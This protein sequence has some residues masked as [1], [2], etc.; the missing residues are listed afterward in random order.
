M[1]GRDAE[2]AALLGMAESARAGEVTLAL[3]TGEAG[4]GKSRLIAELTDRV[5]DALV[6]TGHGVDMST[7]EIPYGVLADTLRDLHRQPDAPELTEDERAALA[8]LLPGRSDE[9]AAGNRAGLMSAALGLLERLAA[10]R[11][12]CWVVEDLHWADAATRDLVNLVARTGHG[13]L[14]VVA[15]VRTDDPETAPEQQARMTA[16]LA[17]LSRLP[18]TETVALPRLGPTDVQRQLAT[19]V[20]GSL[21][22]GLAQQIADLSD[23]L[24]FAI[25][26]LAAGQGRP[27]L[28]SVAAVAAA[29]LASLSTSARLVVEAVAIGDGHLRFR[30]L[31]EVLALSP[32]DVDAGLREAADAG[33]LAD[34]TEDDTLGFRHA[35]L[36]AAVD[37][38][39]PPGARRTWHRRWAEALEAHAGS[40]PADP[41]TLAIAHHWHH[42]GDAGRAIV[43]A[44]AA[45]AAA[46]R[47]GAAADEFILWRR[48]LDLW[49]EAGPEVE[50]IGISRRKA[51]VDGARLSNAI[52][53]GGAFMERQLA[54]TEDRSAQA[55]MH[56][57]RLAFLR[58]KGGLTPLDL[59]EGR[60]A[61]AE[62]DMR[63]GPADELYADGLLGLGSL[64]P[65][66][67]E[68]GDRVIEE[69]RELA[70]AEGWQRTELLAWGVASWRMQLRGEVDL[71]ADQ[72]SEVLDRTGTWTGFD[73]WTLDGNLMWTLVCAGRHR[74]LEAVA[75]RAMRRVPDPRAIGAFWEHIVE[76]VTFSWL[77]TGQWDRALDLIGTSR[78][79]WGEGLKTADLREA[80]I[81]QRRQGRLEDAGI[82]HRSMEAPD[83]PGGAHRFGRLEIVAHDLGSTGDLPAM[84]A[85]LA[86]AWAQGDLAMLTDVL[87]P[88]LRDAAR[89]EADAAA[90]GGA[91]E[92]AAEHLAEVEGVAAKVHRFG[93]L[94]EAWSAELEAQVAR[95]RGE[96]WIPRMERALAAWER[97]GHRYDAALVHVVLAEGLARTDREAARDHL[98]AGLAIA[99]D[100]EAQPLLDRGARL[101][102]RFGGG[103]TGA[104]V[105]TGLTAR[106]IEVLRLL[107]E[108]RTNAQIATEL[109]MSPKTASVHVSRIITKLGASNRTEAAAIAR[110]DGVL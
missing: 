49:D 67:D 23:G 73:A 63:S 38:S 40:L 108:G 91:G 88:L 53:D 25:E 21:P 48:I 33:I 5:P 97:I 12:V 71:A 51:L 2:L 69:S 8:P 57:R 35:L 59:P 44:A 102:E 34:A 74:E 94:G 54:L 11:L 66:T 22:A 72:L 99:A 32:G 37:R 77:Q 110:R 14:L 13:R 107:A 60:L 26:E 103:R 64:L 106:E 43:A 15:T 41:A 90:A 27:E 105:A 104:S 24:P 36:R 78:P 31:E 29:R 70:E 89:F 9:V 1:V 39:I 65:Y 86:E 16:Y 30:L 6:L 68:H 92:D 84:R 95:F 45:T 61:Q 46:R 56:M 17:E 18:G 80:S 81:L 47:T 52:D 28:T 87:W 82:W 79:F 42:A 100:L 76:N 62:A 85:A 96:E 55:A 75:Q 98:D 101:R 109:F 58:A 50:R 19:L 3:V 93:A 10:D 4:I 83:L 20:D 7:G